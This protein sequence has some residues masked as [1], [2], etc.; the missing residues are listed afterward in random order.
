MVILLTTPLG[1]YRFDTNGSLLNRLALGRREY[2]GLTWDRERVYLSHSN[3]DNAALQNERDYRAANIGVV[4]GHSPE[5]V[6]VVATGI[7]QPHQIL[8]DSRGRLLVANT[9]LNRIDV[10]NLDDGQTR[11]I[12]L[13]D[14]TCDMV[15][16]EKLGDHFNGF[17][18]HGD[19]L[20]VVA[21][22]NGRKS[23]VWEL[24][25]ESFDV[26]QVHDTEAEWA[27]NCW[28]C[29]HGLVI[30]DSKY[31][32]LYDVR[33]GESL[34]KADTPNI[35][36]GLA[37]TESYIFVGRSEFGDRLS[38]KY[39]EGGFWV[40]DRKTLKTVDKFF[41]PGTGCTL[42]VRLLDEPDHCHQAPPLDPEMADT[43]RESPL[44]AMVADR[45]QALRYRWF[46][47]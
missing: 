28:V 8:A 22:N 47:R 44:A 32:S 15:G 17:F 43:I 46:N 30:C 10:V 33:T 18:E 25:A 39:S 20:F 40:V 4:R 14:T 41:F 13:N 38:R 45:Y 12:Y 36:R 16:V 35:T 29:E 11:P 21:H 23:K 31:G 9:G 1:V 2:G 34:W 37:A 26:L 3:I 6:S 5:G 27:H 19:T 42:D 7:S 24:D